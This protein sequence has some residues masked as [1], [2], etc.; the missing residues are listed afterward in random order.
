MAGR[1]ALLDLTAT[2]EAQG[3]SPQ[4]VR[5][6]WFSVGLLEVLGV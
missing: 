2:S 1:S 3:V 4:R 5:S 6:M